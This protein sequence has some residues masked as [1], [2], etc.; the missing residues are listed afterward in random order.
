VTIAYLRT[1]TPVGGKPLVDLAGWKDVRRHVISL[2]VSMLPLLVVASAQRQRWADIPFWLRIGCGIPA[3]GCFALYLFTSLPT[4]AEYKYLM[5][6]VLFLAPIVGI[7]FVPK[8]YRFS[9]VVGSVAA[10]GL[11]AACYAWL[12][13]RFSLPNDPT[14][15][16]S[17]AAAVPVTERHAQ[18]S[19]SGEA[20]WIGLLRQRTDPAT[21]VVAPPSDLPLAVLLDRSLYI[22]SDRGRFGRAGYS[23]S[24]ELILQDLRGYSVTA[25]ESRLDT[26]NLVYAPDGEAAQFPGVT[27]RLESLNRPVAIVFTQSAPYLAWLRLHAIGRS[28]GRFDNGE[29]WLLG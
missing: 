21:V 13:I 15:N 27:E 5:A 17:L 1:M 6:G 25:V 10:L 29:I 19:T 20:G 26:V 8:P 11:S 16:N 24:S 23:M 7:F 2:A 12:L 18:V 14:V 9:R 3:I 22:A 28:I 4:E